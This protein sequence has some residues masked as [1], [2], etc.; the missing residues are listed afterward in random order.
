MQI[1]EDAPCAGERSRGW[2]SPRA[3]ADLRRPE[4][5]GRGAEARPGSSPATRCSGS[6]SPARRRAPPVSAQVARNR[7]C[8]RPAVLVA[9][10]RPA[11]LR[12][13]PPGLR[14]PAGADGSF[15]SHGLDSPVYVDAPRSEPGRLYV[16]EQAG[17]IRVSSSG[18]R[19]RP[20]LDIRRLSASGGE[21]GSSRSPST[22]LREEPPLLR[23]L[24]RPNGDTR[25]VEYRSDGTAALPRPRGSSCSSTSRTRTTTAASSQF[26]PDG[27]LY[28]GMGD[29]GSAGDPENRAQNLR[30]RSAKLL[31][32]DVDGAAR[33]ADRRYGLRNPWRSRSTALT[34]T[35]TSAT[36][37]RATGRRSTT[38]R[39]PRDARAT[40][41]GAS[42]RAA[43][44]QRPA[45]RARAVARHPVVVYRH[46]RGCSVTGG[47]VYRG[48]RVPP[49]PGRYF[50]G[51]YCSGQS[52]ACA[53]RAAGDVAP[54]RAV[55]GREPL[56]VR[57][58]RGRRAVRDR[59][60]A[61]SPAL[62]L[63][64]VDRR[65]PDL[66]PCSQ[67]AA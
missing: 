19:A 15:A 42:T 7:R 10:A 22:R 49:P 25:V 37:A 52:G 44:V 27:R 34:A 6:S 31:A 29:G 57:R 5:P 39:R 38:R 60:A 63:I 17:R 13:P 18:K 66:P 47:Y 2:P 59:R 41:A 65:P 43:R 33:A 14:R 40:S 36:S 46:M 48:K 51:D 3:P 67:R 45:A 64:P 53:P 21:Q 32:L 62:G 11:R 54:R 28:V 58:G 20:F 35:S 1:G 55:P 4:R 50:Y 9:V 26:G 8:A 30:H 24:H 23:R 56:L 16:V 12:P 61:S